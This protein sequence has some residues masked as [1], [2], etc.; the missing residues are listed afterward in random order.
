MTELFLIDIEK[1]DCSKIEN[2]K[3]EELFPLPIT[4]KIEKTKNKKL[5][6]DR[7]IT[8][9]ALIDILSG[10]LEKKEIF[11]LFKFQE[12]GKPYLEKNEIYFSVSH[13]DGLAVVA[14]SDFQVGVDIEKIITEKRETVEKICNKYIAKYE[15][16]KPEKLKN[17]NYCYVFGDKV[18]KKRIIVANEEMKFETVP[19]L[20][21]TALE[22]FLKADG[23]GFSK[24]NKT[25]KKQNKFEAHT[26]LFRLN[27]NIFAIATNKIK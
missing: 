22:A 4:Q 7:V 23:S 21:W 27:E 3:L 2:E 16:I 26:Y 12:N 8:Y 25:I 6:R 20:R 1:S 13:T 15:E 18:E 11:N 10:K 24:M 17:V 9:I 14:V 19:F 5:R